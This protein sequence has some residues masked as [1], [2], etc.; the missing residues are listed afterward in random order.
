MKVKHEDLFTSIDTCYL[1]GTNMSIRVKEY[2][3]VV[4]KQ[5]FA[6]SK[7]AQ[8]KK[9]D[10][11]TTKKAKNSENELDLNGTLLKR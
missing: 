6:R 10:N 5:E 7:M 3:R 9:L 4:Y 11:L 8:I 2:V 1:D